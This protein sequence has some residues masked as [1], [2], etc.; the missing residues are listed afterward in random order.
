MATTTQAA[1][2]TRAR[3]GRPRA[4]ARAA[5]ARTPTRTSTS[6]ARA[7]RA[8]WPRRA[9]VIRSGGELDDWLGGSGR[10]RRRRR[11]AAHADRLREA[12][13]RRRRRARPALVAG[14]AQRASSP[15][16]RS[17]TRSI[18]ADPDGARPTFATRRATW[19]AC[20][21]RRRHPRVRRPHPARAAE[22]RDLARLAR[23]LHARLRARVDRGGDPV[24]LE[25]GP[26]VRGR[27]GAAREDHQA[28]EGEGDLP[29]ELAEPEARARDLE[30]GRRAGG[31]PLWADTLGP[32]GS[33]GA[34]YIDAMRSN[35]AA[36]VDGLSGGEVRCRPQA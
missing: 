2:L 12:P 29:R 13:A 25:P 35:T 34:T 15:S 5:A 7:T 36:L 26:G 10:E 31:P 16:A 17:A 32:E 9:L 28:R 14:R 21:A 33:D 8:S 18:L 4:G 1:D 22:A 3:G 6:R 11:E 19:S 20:A 24:A 23:L 30:A 27:H